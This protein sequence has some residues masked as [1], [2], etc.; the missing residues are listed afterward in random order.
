MNGNAN[1]E[2]PWLEWGLE[3]I[4]GLLDGILELVSCLLEL[5][6]SL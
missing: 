5:L 2:R 4:G 3:L 1:R 6:V